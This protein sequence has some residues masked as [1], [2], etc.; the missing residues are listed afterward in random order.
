MK[1]LTVYAHY[2]L[3]R[4]GPMRR[5]IDDWGLRY[6]GIKRAPTISAATSPSQR[7]P[8]AVASVPEGGSDHAG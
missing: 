8:A 6:P 2:A 5:I 7:V 4:E 3:T 1:V